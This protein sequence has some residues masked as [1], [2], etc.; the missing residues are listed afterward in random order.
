MIGGYNE[1]TL[2][3][4]PWILQKQLTIRGS[5]VFSADEG[6]QVGVIPATNFL[7]TGG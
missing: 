6:R 3:P 4:S 1:V 5:W 7:G 2:K